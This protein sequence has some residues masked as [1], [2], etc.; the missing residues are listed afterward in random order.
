M[1]IK[2]EYI[3]GGL[4]ILGGIGVIAYLNKPKKN[5]EGFFNAS[6]KFF[7]EKRNKNNI[8]Y[9]HVSSNQILALK[10]KV[11][12]LFAESIKYLNSPDAKANVLLNN[13][14]QIRLLSQEF[15]LKMLVVNGYTDYLDE[16]QISNFYWFLTGVPS[17]YNA[18]LKNDWKFQG[19]LFLLENEYEFMAN[20]VDTTNNGTIDV[21]RKT[22]MQKRL[23]GAKE[24]FD[25][26]LNSFPAELNYL[27]NK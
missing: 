18:E 4:A 22:Q 15:Y 19:G 7:T 5:S 23:E 12:S 20:R 16:P 3:I 8:N 25:Y 1:E 2:K 13:I 9:G 14:K 17:P 26:F 11:N 21:S 27:K 6:G 24:L 10:N